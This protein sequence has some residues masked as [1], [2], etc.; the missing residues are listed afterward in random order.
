MNAHASTSPQV[1]VLV[2][3]YNRQAY[4]HQ[5]IASILASSFEDFELIIV[6][7][8]STDDSFKIAN[9]L[10]SNDKRCRVYRNERNLG[11]FG[12]RNKA[13]EF[14]TGEFIKYLDS[15]DLI[16]PQSLAIMHQAISANPDASHAMSLAQIDRATPYPEVVPP[17]EAYR[18]EFLGRGC[19]SAG[20][21]ASLIRRSA[22]AEV[23]GYRSVG[24]VSDIDL[25]YRMA[26]KWKTVFMQPALI[27]WRQHEQQAFTA[28][29]AELDYLRGGFRIAMDALRSSHCPLAESEK[30]AAIRRCKQ[31][32]ARRLLRLAVIKWQPLQAWQL[33]KASGLTVSELLSG[34]RSYQ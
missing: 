24:V 32:H 26:A 31:H 29:S 34:L 27:W 11:Q 28:S 7:D 1:S 13:A 10:A 9:E 8:C 21:S 6:D 2:T 17:A 14:A 30:Q 23:G 16:Y 19:M 4:L 20:P 12:N 33:A 3:V 15:D 22:F 5:C 18:R 25:W